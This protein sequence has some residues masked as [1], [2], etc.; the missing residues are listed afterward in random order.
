MNGRNLL[1]HLARRIH[2]RAGLRR[3]KAGETGTTHGG[4]KVG[5]THEIHFF[6]KRERLGAHLE[7]EALEFLGAEPTDT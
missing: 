7:L 1:F 4:M 6:V 3:G 5:L 2:R